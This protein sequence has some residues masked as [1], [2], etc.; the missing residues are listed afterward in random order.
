MTA[1]ETNQ[2]LVVLPSSLKS[3]IVVKAMHDI[4]GLYTHVHSSV[5]TSTARCRFRGVSESIEKTTDF[6]KFLING[7]SSLHICCDVPGR[8]GMPS[9][10]KESHNPMHKVD[11]SAANR[12]FE[13]MGANVCPAISLFH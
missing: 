2:E 9:A 6:L 10:L 3:L 8:L 5:S 4:F 12:V 11:L 1:I 7:F 13:R